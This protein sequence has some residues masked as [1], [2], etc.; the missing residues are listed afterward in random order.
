MCEVEHSGAPATA[1]AR[2]GVLPATL[3]G[4]VAARLDALPATERSLLEDCA[5]VGSNGLV[6]DA[7]ALTSVDAP[8]GVLDA[9]ADRDLLILEDDG[10]R[11]K[12]ELV[13]DVAYGT[14]TRAE[15]ARRHSDLA[16][17]VLESEDRIEFVAHHLATAAELV[18]DLGSITGMQPDIRNRA[19]TALMEAARPVEA[20]EN[21]I[22]SG[23]LFDRALALI[24]A[25]DVPRRWTA[26]LGRAREAA[27]ELDGAHEDALAVLEE[28]TEA[29]DRSM[30]A[31]ALTVLGRV[32][33]DAGRY[34][35]AEATLW[36]AVDAW[37]ALDDTS[38]VAGALRG[39]GVINLFRGEHAEAERLTSEALA[40]FREV[41][42]QRGEAW[43]LQNLA[44]ISFSQGRLADAESRLHKAA[45]LF[46]E[47]GD[48]GGLG[49]ALGLLAFAR[50]NQG[51]L[52]EADSLASQILTE[53][54]E[55]GD[56]WAAGMMKVLLANIALWRGRAEHSL[57]RGN[58]AL[59]LF[60]DIHD[61]WGEV[62][63]CG[64]TIRALNNLTRF[65][66][67]DELCARMAALVVPMHD[68]AMRRN[69][70]GLRAAVAVHRGDPEASLAAIAEITLDDD[71]P[72][73]AVGDTD[74]ALVT[75]L[76]MLQS[77]LITEAIALLEPAFHA[78]EDDGPRYA[79]GSAL[80]LA[81]DAAGRPAEALAICDELSAIRGGSY[82][83]RLYC[84][85][86]AG[87]AFVQQGAASDA[88]AA[89]EE[90]Q[91][92]AF[93]TDSRLDRAIVIV[94]RSYAYA[95]L[96][97]PSGHELETEANLTLHGAGF[98]AHG[99]RT[100]FALASQN[101]PQQIHS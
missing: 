68:P 97:L 98:D 12:S 22:A 29:D 88:A 31:K 32:E 73:D 37:R 17:R 10:F 41:G 16:E 99:W 76:T 86:A 7:L 24:T 57:E 75:G 11:F 42:D 13:R 8:E 95:A 39:L 49:W 64:P 72:D 94:A 43:A 89:F 15:R 53:A 46:G 50:F 34:E 21:W 93:A 91:T 19:I 45:E 65:R 6:A 84:R 51:N 58:E 56:R 38:G 62:M 3:H 4:L 63:A 67:C 55:T 5:V 48:W 26:L 87:F 1:A 100:V 30:I 61:G 9:L 36:R 101:A 69:A 66:E 78:A 96:D 14:L 33:S 18:A 44:W 27:R 54:H 85:L 47:I 23:R 52:D 28:A 79:L 80:G 35:D 83:D 60:R 81:L 71:D 82:L 90:A 40:S 25:D 92:A 70:A 2:I 59:A 74:R 20:A 77:G